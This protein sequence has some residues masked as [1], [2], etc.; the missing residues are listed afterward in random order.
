MFSKK[1][2]YKYGIWTELYVAFLLFFCGYKLLA[3]R[4]KTKLG[5]V[6]LIFKNR[7]NIVA[8]EVKGRRHAKNS[9]AGEV[10]GYYQLKRINDAMDIFLARR[11]QYGNYNIRIDIV[12][13]KGLFS[14]EHIKNVMG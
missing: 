9:V 12:L 14:V 4:Y 3:R 13:V 2:T 11:E 6:D 8:V 5:E 10:V 1:S 7:N